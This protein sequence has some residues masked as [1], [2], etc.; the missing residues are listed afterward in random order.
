MRIEV[1]ALLISIV[2]LLVAFTSLGWNIYKEVGLRAGVRVK[3][4]VADGVLPGRQHGKF[5]IVTATN[6]G[7][8]PVQITGTSVHDTKRPFSRHGKRRHFLALPTFDN[9]LA[10]RLPAPL[11]VGESA[12]LVFAY[13]KDCFLQ[14]QNHTVVVLDS[15]GRSHRPKRS[16]L[17]V[18]RAEYR[19]DFA[20][21]AA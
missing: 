7:P 15:F 21:A 6:F 17:R 13:D 20:R 12:N 11:G 2:S 1:L 4:G 8:G 18:A 16:D 5:I 19:K 3:L 9:P 14:S 10:T